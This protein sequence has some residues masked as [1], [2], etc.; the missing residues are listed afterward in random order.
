MTLLGIHAGQRGFLILRVDYIIV[1]ER[2]RISVTKGPG[3]SHHITQEPQVLLITLDK[4]GSTIE[5]IPLNLQ[6]DGSSSKEFLKKSDCWYFFLSTLVPFLPPR[7]R[8]KGFCQP[9]RGIACARFIGNQ[10]IYVESLQMQGESENRIT[11]KT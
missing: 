2:W 8:D 10:S 4:K 5:Y 3:S 7:S 1:W 11:G 6:K 9:Y